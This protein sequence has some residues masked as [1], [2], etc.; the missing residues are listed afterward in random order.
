MIQ[1]PLADVT[2]DKLDDSSDQDVLDEDEQALDGGRGQHTE[3]DQGERVEA[4][5]RD[6]GHRVVLQ[7]GQLPERARGGVQPPLVLDAIPQ[8]L[9]VLVAV[10]PVSGGLEFGKLLVDPFENLLVFPDRFVGLVDF[11]GDVLVKILALHEHH[12][13]RIDRGDVRAPQERNQ[14]SED[15]REGEPPTMRPQAGDESLEALHGSVR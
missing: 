15:D 2:D 11:F 10:F 8:Q 7:P 12:D 9:H 13:R 14:Q 3:Q 4:V 5:A 6:P 1:R